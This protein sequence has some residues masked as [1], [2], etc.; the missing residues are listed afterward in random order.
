M[1]NLEIVTPERKVVDEE[2]EMVTVP[3]AKGEIGILANHAPL[4]ST[5]K[6][7]ILSYTVKGFTE[8]MVISG[9]FIEISGDKV[10]ILADIAEARE[11]IDVESAR[12]EQAEVQKL[13]G[14]WKG[15]EEEF[16]VELERLQKAQAR[17]DL[18]SAR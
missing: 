8:K 1:I 5:L 6:P 17:L 11:D 10:S 9:G 14:E 3:T 2:A 15:T 13:L 12:G 4:I 7:G 16:E 18:G